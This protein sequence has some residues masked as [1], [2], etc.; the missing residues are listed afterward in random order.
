MKSKFLS[1]SPDNLD[2]YLGLAKAFLS[3]GDWF[4]AMR[5]INDAMK[6]VPTEEDISML[7]ELMGQ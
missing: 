2:A 4:A 1:F 5:T 7:Q 3:S 6:I